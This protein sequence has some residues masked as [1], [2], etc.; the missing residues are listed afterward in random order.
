MKTLFSNSLVLVL[1]SAL[2]IA[3][4]GK[5][6]EQAAAQPTVSPPAASADDSDL[7]KEI[8][9]EHFGIKLTTDPSQPQSGKFRFIA[10]INHHGSPADGATVR[11]QP[12]MPG[13]EMDVAEVDMKSIGGGKYEGDADLRMAGNWQ[14]KVLVDHEGATGTATF[15]F[16]VKE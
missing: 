6:D 15:K 16:A 4:C 2:L 7:G 12:E 5:S 1:V 3:G 14:A 9:G 10:E 13:H 11:I 8:A